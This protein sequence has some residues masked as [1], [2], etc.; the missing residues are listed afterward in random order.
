MWP[1]PKD[2]IE[3]D[4]LMERLNEILENGPLVDPDQGVETEYIPIT[5]FVEIK[6]SE[7]NKNKSDKE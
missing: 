5:G 2:P 3:R 4:R 6:P 7:P 1:I